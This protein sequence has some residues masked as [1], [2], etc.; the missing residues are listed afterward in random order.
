MEI[1]GETLTKKLQTKTKLLMHLEN[2]TSVERKSIL[3]QTK[4]RKQS[5]QMSFK[6]R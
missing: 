4:Y 3:V 6:V 1:Q 2:K 5:R